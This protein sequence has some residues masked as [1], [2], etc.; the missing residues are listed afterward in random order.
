MSETTVNGSTATN[1]APDENFIAE[2]ISEIHRSMM[3]TSQSRKEACSR[4]ESFAHPK[5]NLRIGCWNVRSMNSI[6]KPEQVCKEMDNYKLDVLGISEC[7]WTGIGKVTTQDRKVILYSG[8][9]TRH[10]SG[11]ALILNKKNQMHY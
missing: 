4:K 8:K 7:R 2:V 10:E 5:Q 9:E 3:G 1:C 11:V 6:G